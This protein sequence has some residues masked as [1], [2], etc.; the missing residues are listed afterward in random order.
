MHDINVIGSLQ[1]L[2]ACERSPSIRTIVVRG[3]AGIY[4]A[5]PNAPQSFDEGMTRLFRCAP[6]SS[7]TWRRSRTTSAPTR[8]GTRP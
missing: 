8:A 7:V 1:L 2:A 3:S 4:G 5:E 6:A